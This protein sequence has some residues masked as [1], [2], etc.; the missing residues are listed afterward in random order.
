MRRAI[1]S[2]LPM[3]LLACSVSRDRSSPPASPTYEATSPHIAIAPAGSCISL[4]SECDGAAKPCCEGFCGL[5]G[6]GMA[7]CVPLAEVGELCMG[8]SECRVGTCRDGACASPSPPEQCLSVDVFCGT[9]TTG[10]CC[11]GLYCTP[12]SYLRDS[13]T[14]QPLVA[15]GGGCEAD[16]HCQ[17]GRC[18]DGICRGDCLAMNAECF[19]GAECC[20]GFCTY[21]ADSYAPGYCGIPL[22]AGSPCRYDGWCASRSCVDRVCQ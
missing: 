16:H 21:S 11:A 17:T 19:A 14:C 12:Y 15:V 5:T 4:W 18:P 22:P 9:G 6:Y 8:D 13:Q 1:L 20:S 10:A 2:V 7:Q 3:V